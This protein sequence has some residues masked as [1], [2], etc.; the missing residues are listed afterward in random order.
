M[1]EKKQEADKKEKGQ[2]EKNIQNGQSQD[3][4][5]TEKLTKSSNHPLP[6]I[7]L[8]IVNNESSRDFQEDIYLRVYDAVRHSVNNEVIWYYSRCAMTGWLKGTFNP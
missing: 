7:L 2:R 6:F 1:T 5:G 8:Q 3:K 4:K